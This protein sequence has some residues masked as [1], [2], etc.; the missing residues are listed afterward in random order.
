M[1]Y[2]FHFD[3]NY[4]SEEDSDYVPSDS[5]DSS[6]DSNESDLSE[7][8][9]V[10]KSKEIT[11]TKPIVAPKVKIEKLESKAEV[12][13]VIN[14]EQKVQPIETKVQPIE[15]KETKL[16]EPKSQRPVRTR[17]APIRYQS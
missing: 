8:M 13:K 14:T 9:L 7:E 16:I 15:T 2:L 1:D 12:T 3:A 17:R 5:S 6:W 10:K 4:K 11:K